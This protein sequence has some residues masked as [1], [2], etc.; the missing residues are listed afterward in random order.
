LK[1]ATSAT[2]QQQDLR[3]MA[4]A[5]QHQCRATLSTTAIMP[6][7]LTSP[8]L[9]KRQKHTTILAQATQKPMFANISC[10]KQACPETIS[11]HILTIMTIQVMLGFIK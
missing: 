5:A 10:L 2:I 6:Q 9:T 3:G 7:S 4:Q 11:I 8:Q 1:A